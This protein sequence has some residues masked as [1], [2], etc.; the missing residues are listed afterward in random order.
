LFPSVV[1]ALSELWIRS[2][3]ISNLLDSDLS[4]LLLCAW[5]RWK[6]KIQPL[7]SAVLLAVEALLDLASCL[8]CLKTS[9]ELV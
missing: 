4:L 3:S 7:S 5:L 9:E 1:S 6:I 8:F 2:P